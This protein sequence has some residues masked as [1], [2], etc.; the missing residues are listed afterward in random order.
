[1]L[2]LT[3]MPSN[4]RRQDAITQ[5]LV[6]ARDA[7]VK[8][9]LYLGSPDVSSQLA[10]QRNGKLSQY[11]TTTEDVNMVSAQNEGLD[12]INDADQFKHPPYAILSAIVFIPSEDYWLTSCGMWKANHNY[13]F[14]NVKPTC[15]GQAPKQPLVSEDFQHVINNMNIFVNRAKTLP[16]FKGPFVDSSSGVRKLKFRH[17]LFEVHTDSLLPKLYSTLL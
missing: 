17:V 15:T 10:W 14:A 12:P 11:L 13:S 16:T 1:M 2:D 7:L 8:K 6:T 3:I 9:G 4:S 5:T